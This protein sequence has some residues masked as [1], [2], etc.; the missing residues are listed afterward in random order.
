MLVASKIID[1]RHRPVTDSELRRLV[2]TRSEAISDLRQLMG[3]RLKALEGTWLQKT[4][5]EAPIRPQYPFDLPASGLPWFKRPGLW[6]LVY[7]AVASYMLF[8]VLW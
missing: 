1:L 3:H 5:L 2:Y 4:L 7:L 6:A 8:V